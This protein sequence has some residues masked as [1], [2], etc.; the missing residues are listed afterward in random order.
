MFLQRKPIE[1]RTAIWSA[2]SR[3]IVPLVTNAPRLDMWARTHESSLDPELY[4]LNKNTKLYALEGILSMNGLEK[5]TLA[6]IIDHL[7]RTYCSHIAFEFMHIADE[8]LRRWFMNKA[9]TYIN[10]LFTEQEKLQ[11]LDLITRSETF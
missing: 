5:A 9:G 1:L 10:T 4:G 3:R 8:N 7:E 11:F 2:L 6:Q